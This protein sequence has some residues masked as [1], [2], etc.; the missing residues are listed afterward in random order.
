MRSLALLNSMILVGCTS[1]IQTIS[2][3]AERSTATA[4][5]ADAV[6]ITATT[7]AASGTTVDFAVTGGGQL[8]SARVNTD[9]SGVA[10]TQLTSTTAGAVTVTAAIGQLTDSTTVTYAAASG[11]RL[12]FQTSPSNTIA[13]NLLRPIPSVVVE[14]NS[15]VVTSSTAPITVAITAGSCAA[16]LDASSLM[17]VNAVQGVANFNGLKS[18]TQATGCTL[19]ATGGALQAA[20]STAFDIQ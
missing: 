16:A 7:S 3:T 18:S 6:V 10:K 8:S 20:V 11:P 5:G 14:D 1:A 19:T 17:T 9:S 4:N 15:G 12:R 13:Q 2:V